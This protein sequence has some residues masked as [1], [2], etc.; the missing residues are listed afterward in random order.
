VTART[1]EL[2]AKV[3]E[4]LDAA[5]SRTHAEGADA[6]SELREEIGRLEEGDRSLQ[7]AWN[8]HMATCPQHAALVDP[9]FANID[10]EAWLN[11]PSDTASA[12]LADLEEGTGQ[13]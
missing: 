13:A 8:A 12:Y 6:L 1:D 11:A 9:N 2:L 5:C 7:A 3:E 10:V 4:A